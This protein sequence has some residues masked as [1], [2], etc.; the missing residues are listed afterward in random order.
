MIGSLAAVPPV[1]AGGTHYYVDGKN[2]SDRH[3][4]TSLSA[5]FRTLERALAFAR[6]GGVTI[7]VVGY[8]GFTYYETLTTPFSMYGTATSPVVIE[9]YRPPS[10]PFVRPTI[11]GARI[12]SQPG[13]K[14]WARPSS[15]SYPNV[16]CTP[17]SSPILGY[18]SSRRTSR[19]DIVFMDGTHQLRRPVDKPSRAQLQST[20]GSQYW[21]GRELC[22]HLGVWGGASVDKNPNHHLISIPQYMGIAVNND[23]SYVTIRDLRIIH[24]A[25]A[26]AFYAGTHHGTVKDVELSYNFV[27]GLYSEGD[28]MAFTNVT[29]RRNG[30]QLVKLDRGAQ[31]NVVTKAY[32][33]EHPG[34]GVKIT[35]A[36]TSHHTIQYSTFSGGAVPRWVAS[37]GGETQG[38]DIEQGTHDNL[39]LGNTIR[40]MGRGLML[41]QYDST[42]GPLKGNRIE[43]NYFDDNYRAVVLWDGRSGADGTGSVSFYRNTYRRNGNAIY[44]PTFSKNKTFKNETIFDTVGGAGTGYDSAIY[45]LGSGTRVTLQNVIIN[46]GKGYGVYAGSGA[47]TTATYTHVSSM[48]RGRSKGSVTWS[49]G[50]TTRSPSFLSVDPASALFLTIDRSSP[51]YTAGSGGTPAGARWK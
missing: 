43:R 31:R 21:D 25:G 1:A 23:S 6:N 16:W 48:A 46:T 7:S 28:D 26:I 44:A 27:L 15:S 51:L 39:I 41:Y 13:S 38:I 47:M 5:A 17:W 49:T 34:Q 22:V 42:G 24:T 2:G 19:F 33:V 29:G 11:S 35:G 12:V 32:A 18:E 10:G 45:L 8:E 40:G 50:S 36:T 20:P 30:L 4:G 9:G 14:A 37:Y 3:T